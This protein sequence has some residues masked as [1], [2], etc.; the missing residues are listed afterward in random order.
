MKH[1]CVSKH[2]SISP[3]Y[4]ERGIS[5]CAEWDDFVIF[6]KDMGT[7][8]TPRHQLDRIDNDK[9]YSRE[10]CRWVT[11]TQNRNNTRQNRYI[12]FDGKRQTIAEW[13]NELGI[14][15]RTLNN[16]INRGWSVARA[17]A[18]P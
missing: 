18:T 3:N 10:N 7:R 15:Y 4:R 8:P 5:V 17:L 13:A 14:N 2:P 11:A 16:R 1:R 9:G 12:E 6:L